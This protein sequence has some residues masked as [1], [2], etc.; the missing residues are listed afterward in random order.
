MDDCRQEWPKIQLPFLERH[1]IGFHLH[2]LAAMRE[3]FDPHGRLALEGDRSREAQ[4]RCDGVEQPAE[5]R[6]TKRAQTAL[7]QLTRLQETT[8]E[9]ERRRAQIRDAVDVAKE[10][11]GG[12]HRVA[13]SR[14]ASGEP[15]R[16]Q[17][18]NA[19]ETITERPHEQLAPP[20]R[21][22]VSVSGAVECHP[23]HPCVPGVLLGQ[24]GRDVRTVML[25]D[26]SLCSVHL[27]RRERR[28]VFRVEVMNN[29]ELVRIRRTS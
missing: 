11:C 8:R 6:T 27:E 1:L 29:E 18:R 26:A 16:S 7:S 19:L 23:E 22:I 5:R 15:G 2:G 14:V 24:H 25:D 12:L 13:G 10:A 28:R 4:E 17:V 3:L 21:P 20:D 9:L